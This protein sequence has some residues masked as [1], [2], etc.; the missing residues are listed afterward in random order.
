VFIKHQYLDTWIVS[1]L[2]CSA[3][4]FPCHDGENGVYGTFE[5]I[6]YTLRAV[7]D[8]NSGRCP[9]PFSVNNFFN[10]TNLSVSRVATCNIVKLVNLK[11]LFSRKRSRT[12]S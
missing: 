12:S 1:L 10:L 5:H 11:N 2:L 9:S 4:T 3:R 7:I 8:E 6:F